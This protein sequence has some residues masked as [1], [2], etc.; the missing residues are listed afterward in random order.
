[1]THVDIPGDLRCA[2]MGQRPLARWT[3]RQLSIGVRS[4]LRDLRDAGD[5]PRNTALPLT[6]TNGV[7]STIHSTYH[8]S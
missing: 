6:C 7:P 4:P 3:E 1:M 8:R 2:R 5:N